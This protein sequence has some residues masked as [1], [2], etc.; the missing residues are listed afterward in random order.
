MIAHVSDIHVLFQ[1]SPDK[2]KPGNGRENL[3]NKTYDMYTITEMTTDDACPNLIAF[4][5]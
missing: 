3:A 4:C 2:L 1:H 5:S